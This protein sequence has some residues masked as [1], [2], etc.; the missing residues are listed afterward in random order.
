MKKRKITV[1]YHHEKLNVL[2]SNY[3][4]P[5]ITCSRMIVNWLL[6]SVSD[7]VPPIWG[8]IC[9]EVKHI[10]NGV[11]MWN[12]IKFFIS[13][14][15]RVDI[16]KLCWK[17]KME[18]WVYLSAINVGIMC[19]MISISNTWIITKK[20]KHG[21]KFTIACHLQISFRIHRMHS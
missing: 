20:K 6:G 2:L 16:D 4:F 15:K 8:F 11:R 14:V 9:K 18:D 13:E 19:R 1:V 17:S 12:M 3:Q 10:K 5:L 21:K 7:N